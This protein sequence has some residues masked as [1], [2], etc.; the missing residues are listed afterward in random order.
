M[1][2]IET[3]TKEDRTIVK[4]G[5]EDDVRMRMQEKIK[6]LY[7]FSSPLNNKVNKYEYY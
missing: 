6:Q 1:K 7:R 5:F 3:I 4:V 2:K